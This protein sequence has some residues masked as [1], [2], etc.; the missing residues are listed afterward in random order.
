[1]YLPQSINILNFNTKKLGFGLY[2][3]RQFKS[4]S[5]KLDDLANLAFIG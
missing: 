3:K 4:Q 5:A 1:M 2:I